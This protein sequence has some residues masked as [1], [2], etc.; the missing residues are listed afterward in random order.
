MRLETAHAAY[1]GQFKQI[2]LVV[3][4][5]AMTTML[6]HL[7]YQPQSV[8]VF[9][10]FA[11]AIGLAVGGIKQ[12]KLLNIVKLIMIGTG[13]YLIFNA[14]TVLALG[15]VANALLCLVLAIKPIESQSRKSQRTFI[16]ICF[17]CVVAFFFKD[18]QGGWMLYYSVCLLALI[19]F[20]YKVEFPQETVWQSL[21]VS[22][23]LLVQA[24]PVVVALFFL[25]P[26]ISEPL[27]Q[28]NPYEKNAKSGISDQ[29]KLGDLGKLSLTDEV[30][31]T[32]RFKGS[33]P[34]YEDLYWRGPVY[35]FT[36]GR[37][38]DS[39]FFTKQILGVDQRKEKR[40]LMIR[41]IMILSLNPTIKTG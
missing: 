30:V 15:E 25:F 31:F 35:E 12:Q 14:H 6:P 17:F 8:V 33:P 3:S 19:A 2:G 41:S 16:V 28:W 18:Q 7:F 13:L 9:C 34:A 40:R 39:D 20:V 1:D 11:W 37:V 23:M 32:A 22:S 26:R 24:I 10:L 21:K 38:W 4:V 29:I 27:W 5:L 36:D